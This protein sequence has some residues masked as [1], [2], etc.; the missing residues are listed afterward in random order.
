MDLKLYSR[1]RNSAGQ[2]V[3]T[4]LNIKGIPYQY[5]PV[6]LEEGALESYRKVN[7]QMLLPTLLVD[8]EIVTQSTA[9]V[10]FIE[11]AFA[12]PSLLP[13]D[14]TENHSKPRCLGESDNTPPPTRSRTASRSRFHLDTYA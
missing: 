2:R 14:P 13:Q 1:Y 9:L 6:P 5:I 10:E 7:P 11:E 4:S 3:R 8:G 12:G